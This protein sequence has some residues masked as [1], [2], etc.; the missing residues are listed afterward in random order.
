MKVTATYNDGTT[1]EV[2]N[3]TV[4]DGN[5]LTLRKTSVTISYTENGVTKTTTQGI[6][7]TAKAL[8]GIT[9]T[10]APTNTTYIAGQN[11]DT[12]GMKVTATY[13][14]GTTK[15]V[16]NYTVPDGNNLTVG[17]TSVT[18]NYTENAV[19][20]T[21]TQGITVT[22]KLQIEIEDYTEN[23][24]GNDS[25]IEDISPN[26]T[27]EDMISKI[28]TNG[29]IEIFKGTEKITDTNAKIATGMKI[30]ITLNSKYL[31]YTAVVKGD[32]TGDG[33]MGDADL[34]RM[35]RYKAGLDKKLTGAYLKATDIN[36]NNEKADD[37]DLL[38]LVRIL[39]GL[40]W[41]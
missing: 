19:T 34:L 8:T 5:N 7:V 6:T 33:E 10:K 1:K 41:L 22:E 27:I 20:K 14:D 31:E 32:L 36:N 26:T 38:K 23:K 16:T 30:K 21:T 35:A 3:Y 17:K 15:E 29:K 24:E 13:N 25:Y 9:I 28:D 11:F 37:I 40:D 39:V 18:I 12:T 2:T 4:P